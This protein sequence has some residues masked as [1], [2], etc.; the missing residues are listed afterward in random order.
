MKLFVAL[1]GCGLLLAWPIRATLLRVRCT[2]LAPRSAIVAWQTLAVTASACLLGALVALVAVP[3]G[4]ASVRALDRATSVL[5]EGTAGAL[6]PNELFALTAGL[7]LSTLLLTSVL[8]HTVG[9][10][11]ARARHRLL[12][13]LV[14]TSSPEIPGARV[15]EH[16]NPTAY[17]LPGFRSRVVLSSGAL[18]A[19]GTDEL[20]A[21]L[22]H[23]HTHV[24]ARH[25]LVLLPFVVIASLAP[26]SRLLAT[27]RDELR[28]LIEMA[29][30]DGALA[31]CDRHALA[32]ALCRLTTDEAPELAFAAAGHMTVR[33]V[34]RVLAAKK[35]RRLVPCALWASSTVVLALPVITYQ[36]VGLAWR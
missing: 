7:I 36:L 12:V 11:R 8:A 22:A 26:R 3:F 18:A 33:R 23:E 21:V 32:R 31:H 13:D 4:G 16:A 29:A 10:L 35:A 5:T 17:C 28:C 27:L 6:T 2:V 19:L 9:V 20:V 34:E 14:S 24:R 25:H 1:G 30:D 15:I